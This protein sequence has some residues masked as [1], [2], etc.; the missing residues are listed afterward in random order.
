[1]ATPQF[2]ITQCLECFPPKE[3]ITERFQE[4]LRAYYS[5]H[6]PL[7]GPAVAARP[8]YDILE[9]LEP[10]WPQIANKTED[11][12]LKFSALLDKLQQ[13]GFCA[14]KPDETNLF[15]QQEFLWSSNQGAPA[16][17]WVGHVVG[18][19]VAHDQDHDGDIHKSSEVKDCATILDIISTR[20]AYVLS[21]RRARSPPRHDARDRA[22]AAAG[23]ST[24]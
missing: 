15:N 23:P 19:A 14:L 22:R 13:H 4:I 12:P 18:Y 17:D 20:Y 11:W 3:C 21:L 5:D 10:L 1:M 16:Q 6:I 24:F 9:M 2:C 8:L 7:S